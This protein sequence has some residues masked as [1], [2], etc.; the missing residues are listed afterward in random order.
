MIRCMATNLVLQ[1]AKEEPLEESR[2]IQVLCEYIILVTDVYLLPFCLRQVSNP[3]L[4]STALFH[5]PPTR[6]HS[7]GKTKSM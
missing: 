6:L 3:H 5:S 2:R 7:D 1:A 4:Y